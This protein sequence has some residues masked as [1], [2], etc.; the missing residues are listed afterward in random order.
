MDKQEN[1][2]LLNP[3]NNGIDETA[4]I[5]I[6]L[7]SEQNIDNDPDPDVVLFADNSESTQKES[8]AAKEDPL[9]AAA[10]PRYDYQERSYNKEKR[11]PKKKKEKQSNPLIKT[12]VITV[13]LCMLFS[14]AAGFGGGFLANQLNQDNESDGKEVLYQSVVRT[15]TDVKSDKETLSVADIASITSNSVVAITTETV[16]TNNRMQQYVTQGAG[17]GVIITTTG[18]IVTNNHVIANA[19]KI[20]V[21]LADGSTHAAVL[22]GTDSKTDIAVIKIE[23]TELTAAVMGDSATLVVGELAVAIGNPLGQLGGT[24]TSGI[25]SAL[26]REITI[27]GE[28][29]NLLQ[30]NAAI[31]P[32]NSGGGLFNAQGELIGIVNAKSSGTGVEGLG[33]AIPINTVKP[34]LEQLITYGYVKG[35][36]TLGVKLIDINNLQTAA[37]YNEKTFG[38]Y[39]VEVDA[40]SNAEKLGIQKG[41]YILTINGNTISEST[42]VKTAL[43]ALNVGDTATIAVLRDGTQ[44]KLTGTLEETETN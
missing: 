6:I 34:I 44:I 14:A 19:S 2:S 7:Q 11:P 25:I 10:E 24:V 43:S 32:G 42:D 26:D 13:I 31:N 4:D 38:V 37:L 33:F 18:Y 41:D 3:E 27:D 23:G 16:V 35:R 9:T 5:N 39:V 30:T 29:M 20:T 8:E 21:T 22:V 36:V 15:S 1:D 28:T 12:S 17:S 40:D